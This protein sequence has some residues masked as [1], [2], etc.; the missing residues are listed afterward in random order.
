[1]AMWS[2][3]YI[4]CI[5]LVNLKDIMNAL[6]RITN[7]VI[8]QWKLYLPSCHLQFDPFVLSRQKNFRPSSA[9]FVF[10]H[11]K[12]NSRA[13]I[14]PRLKCPIVLRRM[15]YMIYNVDRLPLVY[16]TSLSAS[17]HVL[18]VIFIDACIAWCFTCPLYKAVSCCVA[19]ACCNQCV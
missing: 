7:L 17:V 4:S 13:I 9:F 15:L 11:L 3:S 12:I 10:L 18:T 8:K 2:K 14:V 1:M 6:T 5:F 19:I 16:N